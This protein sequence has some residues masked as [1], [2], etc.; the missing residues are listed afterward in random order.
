MLDVV[1]LGEPMLEFNEEPD[2]RYRQGFGGDTSNAAIAAARLGAKVGYV[3]LLGKDRFGDLFMDLWAREG[4][5]TDHVGRHAT[6][7]TAVYIVNHTTAGHTFTYLRAGSAA[8]RMT[9]ADFPDASFQNTRFLHVS[10]VSQAI[11]DTA[12]ATAAYAIAT[13][14]RAGVRISYDTNLRLR[15]WPLEVAREVIAATAAGADILK[16]SIED[17]ETLTGLSEPGV[18]AEHYL[19]K[20]PELVLVTLGKDGALAATRRQQLRLAAHAVAAVDATGAGDAFAG[21]VLARL[22]AG[23]EPFVAARYANAA[24]AL[25][26]TGYG[27]VA[28]LPRPAD[29]AVLLATT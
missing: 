27:A 20:G 15:L 29:V 12:R 11:S 16:T 5:T 17:A 6:A 26:T 9:P 18:V 14:K 22:A 1:A 3:T 13:A 2:G 28:P 19:S 24:A 7:P 10:A 4:V 23:D 8:S 25:A 21:A